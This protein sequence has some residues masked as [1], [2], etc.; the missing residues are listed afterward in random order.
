MPKL[1]HCPDDSSRAPGSACEVHAP[2]CRLWRHDLL[3]QCLEVDSVTVVG[4]F[5]RKQAD[6]AI[7]IDIDDREAVC[8]AMTITDELA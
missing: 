1:S 5:E 3:R 2:E 8:A 4:L 7:V 6:L